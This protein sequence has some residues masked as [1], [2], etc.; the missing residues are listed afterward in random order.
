MALHLPIGPLKPRSGL[1]P[2]PRCEPSTY[3]HIATAPSGPVKSVLANCYLYNQ[4]T[5]LTVSYYFIDIRSVG[6]QF[7]TSIH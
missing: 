7:N 6:Y 5:L 3:Q 1:E 2:V 4:S